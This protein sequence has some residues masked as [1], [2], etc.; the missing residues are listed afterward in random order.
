[1]KNPI[2]SWKNFQIMFHNSG[3]LKLAL[4]LKQFAS[5]HKPLK[6]EELI[7]KWTEF[8]CC[9]LEVG[10]KAM[11][12]MLEKFMATEEDGVI[13]VLSSKKHLKLLKAPDLNV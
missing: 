9:D 7:T 11:N 2:E 10:E 3:P 5:E 12:T 4:E 6:K 13:Y 1:M 8:E